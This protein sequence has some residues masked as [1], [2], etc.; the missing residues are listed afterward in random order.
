MK[1]YLSLFLLKVPK[2]QMAEENGK[3]SRDP[4]IL[5]LDFTSKVVQKC[6]KFC[7]A[8]SQIITGV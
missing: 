4:S 2:L 3:G 5:N 6:I 1:I 7:S 8:T